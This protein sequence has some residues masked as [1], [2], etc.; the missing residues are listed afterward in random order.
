MKIEPKQKFVNWPAHIQ[1]L[2]IG[3]DDERSVIADWCEENNRLEYAEWLRYEGGDDLQ[4]AITDVRR[5]VI[6]GLILD[7]P[8]KYETDLAAVY[9][10]VGP[11]RCFRGYA[12]QMLGPRDS[13]LFLDMSRSDLS[14]IT[15]ARMMHIIT[16]EKDEARCLVANG[17]SYLDRNTDAV[18]LS[19]NAMVKFVGRFEDPPFAWLTPPPEKWQRAR[20][21]STFDQIREVF[22]DEQATREVFG[23]NGEQ[24]P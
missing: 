15:K 10:H 21:T 1:A 19:P 24:D 5:R 12:K 7:E 14:Q 9:V 11:S 2:D 6:R 20:L 17:F 16:L 8:A 4:K 3:A 13:E 18:L 22:G 23:T